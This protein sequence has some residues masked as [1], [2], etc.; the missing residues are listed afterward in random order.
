MGFGFMTAV[1][2]CACG[3]YTTFDWSKAPGTP[4]TTVLCDGPTVG[5]NCTSSVVKVADYA[6]VTCVDSLGDANCPTAGEVY[7]G[8]DGNYSI[9]PESYT[10]E[11]KVEDRLV[12]AV[13]G[14]TWAQPAYAAESLTLAMDQCSTLAVSSYGGLDDWRV[15]AIRE[16]ARILSR[17]ATKP[18]SWPADLDFFANSFWWSSTPTKSNPDQTIGLAGNW[19]WTYIEPTDGVGGA[20]SGARYTFCVSGPTMAGAWVVN[21]DEVTVSHTTTGLMWHRSPSPGLF[22]WDA[23]LQYCENSMVG[24][25]DDW[26]LPTLREYMSVLDFG[27]GTEYMSAAFEGIQDV[28]MLT[29]T[30]NRIGATWTEVAHVNESSGA[31]RQQNVSTLMGPARCVRGPN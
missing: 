5:R 13:T 14:L 19:P 7:F 9:N 1:C 31:V 4:Q 24:G 20:F 15:P 18:G 22:D 6:E 23:G 17:N 28:T 12:E 29:S 3:E 8:Q 25:F 11:A 21:P 16:L 27:E 2:F 10:Y 30:P 26:R